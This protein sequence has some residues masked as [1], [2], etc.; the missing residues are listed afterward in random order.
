MEDF[1]DAEDLFSTIDFKKYVVQ[2]RE[3]ITV[4]NSEYLKDNNLFQGHPC[5]QIPAGSDRPEILK[6]EKLDEES[7][8][9]LH[10]FTRKLASKLR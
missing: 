5:L 7:R 3:G 6:L 4:K 1:L 2:V 10:M 9:N 8:E